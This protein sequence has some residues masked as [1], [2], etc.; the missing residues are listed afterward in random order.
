M[1]KTHELPATEH[2]GHDHHARGDHHAHDEAGSGPEHMGHGGHGGHD[3][4]AMFRQRFWWSLLLTAPIVVT[5]HMVMDWFNYSLD[6]A[7]MDLIGP[8]LGTVIF[9][10]AGWPFLCQRPIQPN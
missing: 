1:P 6:F 7:G 2:P 9:V 5:S 10:W 4:V 3:H 8:V